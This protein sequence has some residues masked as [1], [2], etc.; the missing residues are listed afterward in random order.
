M[1]LHCWIGQRTFL[2]INQPAGS[3]LLQPIGAVSYFSWASAPKK[4]FPKNFVFSWG[5]R[6]NTEGRRLLKYLVLHLGLTLQTGSSTT[7]SKSYSFMNY[8]SSKSCIFPSEIFP[9]SHLKTINNLDDDL[10]SDFHLIV[11]RKGSERWCN[12]VLKG[13]AVGYLAADWKTEECKCWSTPF[14]F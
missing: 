7:N 3:R 6:T 12:E 1:G 2:Y 10:A 5:Y 9:E 4:L 14:I 13:G 11:W 8:I